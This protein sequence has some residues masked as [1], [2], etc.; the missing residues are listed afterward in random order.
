MILVFYVSIIAIIGYK[1]KLPKI[2]LI[3]ILIVTFFF[4]LS[5]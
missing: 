1:Y 2:V 4:L 3:W 5:F